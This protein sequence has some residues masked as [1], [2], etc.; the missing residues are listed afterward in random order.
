MYH[1][2]EKDYSWA[3]QTEMCNFLKAGGGGGGV[4]RR[5]EEILKQQAGLQLFS[6]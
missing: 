5:A 4:R 2:G 6:N 3:N 1:L